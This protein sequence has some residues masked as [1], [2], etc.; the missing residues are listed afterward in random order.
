MNYCPNCG[1]KLVDTIIDN[2]QVKECKKCKYIDW[3]NW[4]YL[5]GVVVAFNNKGEFLMVKLHDQGK[6][7]FP[8]GYRDIGETVEEAAIREFYEETGNKIKDIELYQTYTS[9]KI[10]LVWVVY[11][12]KIE[13]VTFQEND[14]VSEILFVSK[15][16]P[17]DSK[18]L[19]GSLTERLY[20]DILKEL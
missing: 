7:T 18:L 2:K 15:N 16:N 5:A 8:G 10:R 1:E 4:V 3:D 13:E 9:D 12:A 17:I 14:E 6:I 11:K 20:Q 19:R